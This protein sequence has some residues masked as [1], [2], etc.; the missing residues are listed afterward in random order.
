MEKLKS[1]L[2]S[3]PFFFNTIRRPIAGDQRYTKNFVKKNLEKYN[4]KTVLDIGCG[5][6][7]F[8]SS[9]P[10]EISCYLGVD[11][12]TKYIAYAK[13]KYQSSKIKFMVQ[14]VTEKKF[15]ANHKFDAVILISMLHHLSD[16]DLA[17]ILPS[18]KKIT[19]KIIIIAD[20]LP[21]PPGLLQKLMVKL[22]QGKYIRNEEEKIK[23][24]EKYF[25]IISTELIRSRLALQY[26]IICRP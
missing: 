16:S 2:L 22:D 11:L 1:S 7:D 12:N 19:K 20:L 10:L 5:T 14:D 23:L 9:L 4:S 21:K 15:Y 26:G 17:K 13:S 25:S 18:I 3:N 8:A 6:G 24:L